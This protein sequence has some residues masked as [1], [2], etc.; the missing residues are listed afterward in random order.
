VPCSR[1]HKPEQ[2][3][4]DFFTRYKLKIFTCESCHS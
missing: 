4:S 3:G 2:Q 1:C